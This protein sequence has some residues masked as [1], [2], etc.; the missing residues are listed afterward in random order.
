[1]RRVFESEQYLIVKEMQMPF[2]LLIK[3]V[4][5]NLISVNFNSTVMH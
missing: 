4:D 2:G 3:F 5:L 1:M